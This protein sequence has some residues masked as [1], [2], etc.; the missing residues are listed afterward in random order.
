[1]SGFNKKK[2][3]IEKKMRIKRLNVEL[4]YLN[5]K[6]KNQEKKHH[7]MMHSDNVQASQPT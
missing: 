2:S 3:K 1:M 5:Y 6:K 7:C 4:L